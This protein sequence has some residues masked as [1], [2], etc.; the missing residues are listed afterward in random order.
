MYDFVPLQ[1]SNLV[2]CTKRDLI[3]H[4]TKTFLPPLAVLFFVSDDES[5]L[6]CRHARDESTPHPWKR[7]MVS[8]TASSYS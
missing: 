7:A 5:I 1:Q 2:C 8:V 3:H 4:S 6:F